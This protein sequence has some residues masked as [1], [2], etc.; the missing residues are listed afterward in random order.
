MRTLSM[1]VIVPHTTPILALAFAILLSAET[2]V[3]AAQ[4]TTNTEEEP[5]KVDLVTLE[6]CQRKDL[7]RFRQFVFHL[8]GCFAEVHLSEMGEVLMFKPLNN[9][10][11]ICRKVI[12]ECRWQ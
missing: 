7:L 4:G 8:Y 6:D 1:S 3:R 2:P 11:A 9:T 12:E 5:I 10:D